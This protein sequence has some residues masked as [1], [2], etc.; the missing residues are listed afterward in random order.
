MIKED[1]PLAS[2]DVSTLSESSTESGT[3]QLIS[4]QQSA[5]LIDN[6]IDSH[7]VQD[8]K[9]SIESNQSDKSLLQNNDSTAD[10]SVTTATNV[11]TAESDETNSAPS[12]DGCTRTLPMS[13]S[14]SARDSRFGVSS[15]KT[16]AASPR[17][18][19]V[20]PRSQPPVLPDMGGESESDQ[21]TVVKAGLDLD[22]KEKKKPSDVSPVK[23][24]VGSN[25]AKLSSLERSHSPKQAKEEEPPSGSDTDSVN[26]PTASPAKPKQ[27]STK[28]KN[29]NRETSGKFILND[30]WCT[31]FGKIISRAVI[32]G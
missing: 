26:T 1:A 22:I 5:L 27:S 12:P 24:A 14:M 4:S 23:T 9:L 8:Q 29:N 19:P 2:P 31:L 10:S 15:F 11:S 25:I 17:S 28:Q 16:F 20:L 6:Q 7:I 21:V 32:H 30:R 13:H 18:S 3:Q